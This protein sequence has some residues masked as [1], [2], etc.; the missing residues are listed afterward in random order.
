[1]TDSFADGSNP[2]P[3]KHSIPAPVDPVC[4]RVCSLRLFVSLKPQILGRE[5]RA[6]CIQAHTHTHTRARARARQNT[7]SNTSP[8]RRWISKVTLLSPVRWLLESV[9]LWCVCVCRGDECHSS[10]L[11]LLAGQRYCRCLLTSKFVVVTELQSRID[12]LR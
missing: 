12:P 11:R 8:Y 5:I 7:M 3:D 6:C 9:W 1:M 4:V 10:L 2:A